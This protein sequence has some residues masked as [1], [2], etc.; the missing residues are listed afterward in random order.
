MILVNSTPTTAALQREN[1][2]IP[3]VFTNVGDPAG[4]GFVAG[5]NRPSGNLTG[6]GRRGRPPSAG[7]RMVPTA[8]EIVRYRLCPSRP[9]RPASQL[10]TSWG[11]LNMPFAPG[12]NRST[13]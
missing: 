2:T 6:F 8:A 11:D 13:E 12:M 5:L 10:R 4:S 1:Q 3:I 9:H 7:A